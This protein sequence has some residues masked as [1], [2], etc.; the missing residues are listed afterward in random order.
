M[1]QSRR[2]SEAGNFAVGKRGR[3]DN[4]VGQ[5]AQTCAENHRGLRRAG[6]AAANGRDGRSEAVGGCGTLIHRDYGDFSPARMPR[7]SFVRFGSAALAVAMIVATSAGSRASG[8]HMSVTIEKP[9]TF[10]PAWT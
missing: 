2:A 7:T 5:L 1:S 10:K 8:K 9:T 3:G 6:P 4:F